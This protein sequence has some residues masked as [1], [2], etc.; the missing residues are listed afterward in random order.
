MASLIK[1]EEFT[2]LI[3]FLLDKLNLYDERKCLSGYD[4]F[5]HEQIIAVFKKVLQKTK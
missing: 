3:V 2:G 4:V 5:R 1:K